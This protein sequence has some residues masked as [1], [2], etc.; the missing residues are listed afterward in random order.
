[1]GREK[2]KYLLCVIGGICLGFLVQVLFEDLSA[3]GSAR[4]WVAAAILVAG[5]GA[6]CLIGRGLYG[7]WSQNHKE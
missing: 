6:I 5:V 3:A 1:M 2:A 7:F 4:I